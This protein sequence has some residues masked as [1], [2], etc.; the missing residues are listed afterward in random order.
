MPASRQT[1]SSPSALDRRLQ[2]LLLANRRVRDGKIEPRNRSPWL[3]PLQR[4]QSQRL[5]AG[6]QDFLHKPKTA[7]AARFFLDDL[8]G[9]HDVSARD[10]DVERVL[11]LMRKLLPQHLIETAADAIELAVISHALDLRVAQRLEQSAARA[12]RTA[13]PSL[14]ERDY[15]AAY[16]RVGK[17][18]LRDR[19]IELVLRVGATLDEAVHKPW[20]PRLLRASRLPAKLAGLGEL[21]TF[22]ERGFAA[23]KALQGADDFMA[24][25]ARRERE[26][27]RRLLAGEPHPF[28]VVKPL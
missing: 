12:K 14:S 9:D 20:I 7:P 11:P 8:Y 28:E 23:F 3:A 6:F 13:P 25:I 18:L 10:R 22:L 24:E 1:P 21:Q 17:P 15:A 27:S 4:W 26:V 5:E 2:R 19:Q 16:R